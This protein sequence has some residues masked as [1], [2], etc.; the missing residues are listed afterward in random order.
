MTVNPGRRA[1]FRALPAAP[2][3]LLGVAAA[4]A[5]PPPAPVALPRIVPGSPMSSAAMNELIRQIEY[6]INLARECTGLPGIVRGE[7]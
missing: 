7:R 6:G 5:I 3:V 1:F 2:A 4:A